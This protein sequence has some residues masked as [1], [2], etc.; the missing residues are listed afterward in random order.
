[1][2]LNRFRNIV[3]ASLIMGSVTAA[4]ATTIEINDEEFNTRVRSYLLEHP[5]VII[6]ALQILK[7]REAEAKS[8]GD[9]DLVAESAVAL[10]QQTSLSHI[11]GNPQGSKVLVEFIDYQC[12]YCRRAHE[13]T[14]GMLADDPELKIIYRE[15]P[16]LGPQS[17]IYAR[18][19]LAVERDLGSIY[20]TALSDYLFATAKPLTKANI[21]ASVA[22][23]GLTGDER[24]A[25]A[26]YLRNNFDSIQDD[27]E[28]GVYLVQTRQLAQTLNVT[29]TPGF[30]G[31][32]G[33]IRGFAQADRLYSIAQ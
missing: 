20:Y 26:E 32:S 11:G 22:G 3:V 24:Y 16:I 15:Y 29:G 12:G 9:L 27:V 19:A 17:E 8:K 33:I 28:I 10:F 14:Q 13:I 2:T 5:E 1:M 23:M 25:L 6:E 30:A 7:A 4:N 18:L 31:P 21:D